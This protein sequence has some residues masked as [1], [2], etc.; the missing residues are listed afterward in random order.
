KLRQRMELGIDEERRNVDN[1]GHS[2]DR[3]QHGERALPSVR[4]EQRVRE[5]Q[6]QP[7]ADRLRYRDV[8]IEES[9]AYGKLLVHQDDEEY[10]RATEY[11]KLQQA[12]FAKCQSA[13]TT[14]LD[15]G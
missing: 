3:G 13:S 9:R 4:Y 15:G 11:Q 10:R 14:E 8:A 6:H 5:D 12:E 7:T 1:Q 2:A